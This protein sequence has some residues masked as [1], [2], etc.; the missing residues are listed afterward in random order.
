MIKNIA[1][2]F[3]LGVCSVS[4]A[5]TVT[6]NPSY[7]GTV[8]P[9]TTPAPRVAPQNPS[10]TLTQPQQQDPCA[11]LTPQERIFARQLNPS[12]RQIFCQQFSSDQRTT[13]MLMA[14]QPDAT[15]TTMTPDMAVES[16]VAG[17]PPGA[18]SP[19]MPQGCPA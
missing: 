19:T 11:S 13:A 17:S 2:G 14:S 16:I 9:K 4:F 1:F 3:M 6:P 12:N 8:A 5:A 10:G 18:T 15:G 7:P